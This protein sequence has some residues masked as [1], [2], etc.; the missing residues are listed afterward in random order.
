MSKSAAFTL[1]LKHAVKVAS[2]GSKVNRRVSD[3]GESVARLL[4]RKHG[5]SALKMFG[6]PNSPEARMGLGSASV[7]AGGILGSALLADLISP[8][9]DPYVDSVTPGLRRP[10]RMSAENPTAVREVFRY[11]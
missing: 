1:G 3:T 4:G 8:N 2:I 10:L 7:G 11:V 9:N 6:D 5:R